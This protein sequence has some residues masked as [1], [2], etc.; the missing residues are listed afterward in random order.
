LENNGEIESTLKVQFIFQEGKFMATI[1]AA[2]LQLQSQAEEAVE[3][4]ILAGFAPEKATSFF[5]NPPGQHA[6]YPI[7]GDRYQSPSA[8]EESGK[9][10]KLGTAFVEIT[11]AVIGV[12]HDDAHAHDTAANHAN[13]VPPHRAGMLVAVEVAD[14]INQDKAIALLTRLGAHHIEQAEG[15]I[16]GGEWIDFDPLNEP[17]YL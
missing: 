6:I 1:I 15:K 3:Q 16:V 10:A 2:S 12:K 8:A 11:E 14:H 7:G 5:I 13:A 9:S 4:L 17:R